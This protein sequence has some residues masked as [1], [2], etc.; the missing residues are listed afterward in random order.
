MSQ[1]RKVIRNK[2]FFLL[3]LGQIISQFGDRLNQMALIAFI[4]NRAPG[5]TFELAKIISIT[6]IPVFVIGPIAGIYVDRW[7][8]R[9]TMFICDLI[10]AVLVCSIP[11]FLI[12]KNSVVPLYVVVFLVFCIG[13]FFVPAKMSIIPDLVKKEDLLLANSLVNTTGMIAAA[14]GLGIGGILVEIVGVKGGFF[15]DAATFLISSILIFFVK[16]HKLLK[17]QPK[18]VLDVSKEIVSVIRESVIDDLKSVISFLRN[19]KHIRR[20]LDILFILWAALGSVYVVIIVFIQGVFTSVV[21]DLGI[22]AVFLGCGLFFGSLIYGKLGKGLSYFRMIFISLIFCGLSLLAFTMLSY[23]LTSFILTSLLAFIVGISAA[24]IM[25]AVNTLVHEV[26]GKEMMGKVFSAIE[27]IVHFAFLI[28]MFFASAV[29]ERIGQYY[30]LIIIGVIICFV[31]LVG[32][33]KKGDH[34]FLKRA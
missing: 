20:T 11:F 1:F 7:D 30:M 21:K 22:L 23:Y 31:G 3:W 16:P 13:R 6:I 12:D 28:F 4:F 25:I 33:F 14:L 34:F 10:R 17:V 27:I 2:N 32:L 29:A 24:P 26:T 9:K 8:R 5:S 19:Q 18:D 15:I